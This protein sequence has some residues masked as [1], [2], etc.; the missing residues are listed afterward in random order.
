MTD[1][2]RA[3]LEKRLIRLRKELA[4]IQDENV[5]YAKHGL[6]RMDRSYEYNLIQHIVKLE[7]KLGVN[8]A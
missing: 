6:Q 4:K 7:I 3:R 1:R 2:K 8:N 5:R